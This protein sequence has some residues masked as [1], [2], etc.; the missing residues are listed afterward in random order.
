MTCRDKWIHWCSERLWNLAKVTQQAGSSTRI[1]FHNG[2]ASKPIPF[3]LGCMEEKDD[4][5]KMIKDSWKTGREFLLHKTSE[6]ARETKIFPLPHFPNQSF[7]CSARWKKTSMKILHVTPPNTHTTPQ[8]TQ[9]TL[10]K[11]PLKWLK[12][13]TEESFRWLHRQQ[14]AKIS[15]QSLILL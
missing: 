3:S 4:E 14:T 9:K 5:R 13:F 2:L 15:P 6:T 7:Q 8:K 12:I 11:N 10:L 1:L